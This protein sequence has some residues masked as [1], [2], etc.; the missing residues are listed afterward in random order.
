[1][2]T[3]FLKIFILIAFIITS[4]CGIKQRWEESGV[5]TNPQSQESTYIWKKGKQY[6]AIV[7]TIPVKGRDKNKTIHP[8]NI[9][10]DTISNS[11]EKIN[12]VLI[13]KK[14]RKSERKPVFSEA[15]VQ[16]AF[17]KGLNISSIF[18]CIHFI[19]LS[20]VCWSL[21][22]ILIEALAISGM[23]FTAELPMSKVGIWIE[24]GRKYSLPESKGVEIIFCNIAIR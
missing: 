6:I 10:V 23:T 20:L 19:K 15:N 22:R 1:M 2:I 17:S 14:G 21:K 7:K 8:I 12:Y 5:Y 24:L 3:K 18:F 13:D 16:L 11:L 4:S 9:S